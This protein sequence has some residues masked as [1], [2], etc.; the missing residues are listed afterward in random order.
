MRRMMTIG[1]LVLAVAAVAAQTQAV[2]S[3]SRDVAALA[4]QATSPQ[5]VAWHAHRHKRTT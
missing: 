3:L 2:T 5:W 1:A 4:S